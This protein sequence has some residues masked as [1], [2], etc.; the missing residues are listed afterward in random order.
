MDSLAPHYGD[1]WWFLAYHAMAQSEDGQLAAARAKIERSVAAN[2]NNAHGAH[3]FAHIC[4]ES[5]D[6][7]AARSFLS[8]WLATYPREG[9]FYGHL[10]WHLSLFE[11]QA[12]NWSQ[13]FRLYQDT[14]PSASARGSTTSM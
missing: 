3:G 9:F 11:I 13:A 5:G 6:L 2:P 10:S 7:D 1:D 4:Y 14:R 12:G 8:T